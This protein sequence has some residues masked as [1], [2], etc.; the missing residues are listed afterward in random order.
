MSNENVAGLHALSHFTDKFNLP[1]MVMKYAD[2]SNL[3]Q[4]DYKINSFK[5]R[6]R[7]RKLDL[8]I[9]SI[10]DKMIDFHLFHFIKCI[11]QT[12]FSTT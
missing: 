3:N 9:L 5:F 7:D 2:M 11:K 1:E 6:K 12:Y 8:N 10:F 4:L